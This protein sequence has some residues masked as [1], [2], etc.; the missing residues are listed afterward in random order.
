[1]SFYQTDDGIRIVDKRIAQRP[2][3]NKEKK[4][5]DKKRIWKSIKDTHNT[6]KHTSS[7]DRQQEKK[8]TKEKDELGMKTDNESFIIR[9]KKLKEDIRG[10]EITNMKKV[11]E[12]KKVYIVY[13]LFRSKRGLFTMC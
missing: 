11:G 12:S 10:K 6:N 5:R 7:I 13:E 4:D 3:R 1:M 9:I 2:C 8:G